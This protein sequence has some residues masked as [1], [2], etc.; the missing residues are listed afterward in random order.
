[1]ATQLEA[2]TSDFSYFDAPMLQRAVVR[3]F[4]KTC[5]PLS[6]IQAG[7]PIEFH[8][9]AVDRQYL[10]LR[11]S[12]LEVCCYIKAP[13]GT[14]VTDATKAGPDNN[15]LNSLFRSVEVELN[16]YLVSDANSLYPYRSMAEALTSY[17]KDVVET[18]LQAEGFMIDSPGNL[19]DTNPNGNNSGLKTRSQLFA[20]RNTI[21]L[22]GRPNVDIFHADRCLPPNVEMRL[23]LNPSSSKF[24]IKTA[25]PATGQTQVEYTIHIQCARLI[26]HVK[27]VSNAFAEAHKTVLKNKPYRIPITRMAAKILTISKGSSNFE[28]DIFDTL[29]DRIVLMMVDDSSLNGEYTSNP[30]FFNHFNLKQLGLKV[31]GQ[32]VPVDVVKMDFTSKQYIKAYR[33]L[34]K[35]LELSEGDKSLC[36][37]PDDWANGYTFFA[38]RIVPHPSGPGI[39]QVK[40]RDSNVRLELQFDSGSPSE[41]VS[42]IV[43]AEHSDALLIYESRQVRF[44]SKS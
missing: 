19:A 32:P 39:E 35:Q 41:T 27:E 7:S 33:F 43:L 18:R 16:G 12:E 11:H 20:G 34:L 25:T 28:Q 10:D 29:P 9:P 40:S 31:N 37:S 24:V 36:L 26:I 4:D 42:V 14:K 6:A 17:S 38:I 8:V 5:H 30:F 2:L 21:T 23:R 44:E 15:L 13:D 3:E 1:M 22:C